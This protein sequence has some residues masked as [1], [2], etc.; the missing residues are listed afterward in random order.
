MH[1]TSLIRERLGVHGELRV[2]RRPGPP[3][4]LAFEVLREAD[5]RA[6][7]LRVPRAAGPELRR[8]L[9]AA[10]ARL[11]QG[12]EPAF[13]ERGC[14]LL[15]RVALA[16]DDELAAV[17]LA[18]GEERAFAL[19]RRGLTRQGWAWTPE[20]VVVPGALAPAFL[21]RVAAALERLGA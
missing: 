5:G 1:G 3:E 16:A 17:L 11:G 18:E 2:Q 10:A 19:W 20:V 15:A 4:H 6:W 12:T 9:A 7:T 13:D 8:L 14:A 21:A